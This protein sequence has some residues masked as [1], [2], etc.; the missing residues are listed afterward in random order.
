MDKFHSEYAYYTRTMRDAQQAA[1][2]SAAFMGTAPRDLAYAKA[3][4]RVALRAA[5]RPGWEAMKA[6]FKHEVEVAHYAAA[7]GLW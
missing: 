7:I 6:Q 3:M 1:N 5:P 2:E 4:G